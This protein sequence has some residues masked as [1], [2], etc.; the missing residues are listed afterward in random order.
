MLEAQSLSSLC[1]SGKELKESLKTKAKDYCKIDK[2]FCVDRNIQLVPLQL[3]QQPAVET[4]DNI[5][6]FH[7]R[8]DIPLTTIKPPVGDFSINEIFNKA[9]EHAKTFI[10]NKQYYSDKESQKEMIV[11]ANIVGVI[12]Q[13]GIG[14]TCLTKLILKQIIDKRLFKSEYAFYLQFREVDYNEETNLLSFLAKSLSLSW[15]NNSVRRNAVLQHLSSRNDITLIMDGFD[16]AVIDTT[17]ANFTIA[18]LYDNAKPETFIKNILKGTILEN[19]KKIITSRPRQL[20][21]IVPDL[22][23]KYLLNILGLDLE[24]QY[25]ICKNICDDNTD[26]VFNYIQQH[27]SIATYCYVPCNCIL[28]MHAVHRVNALQQTKQNKIS[29]PN[30]ISGILSVV[31]CL[32][33]SSPHARDKHPSF[34]LRKLAYLAWDGF[35]NR[36]FCFTET[37]LHKTELGKDEINLFFVT[38]MANNA[39]TIFGGSPLKISYFSHL[40][41][42]EFLS[43]LYLIYFLPL[44]VFKKL[45]IGKH[46]GVIK[47]KPPQLVVT[48]GNWELVTKFM[49][50]ICNL[51]TQNMLQ[52]SFSDIGTTVSDKADLL[53]DF[54]I[55]NFVKANKKSSENLSPDH[56]YFQNILS[57][58]TWVH[59][60]NDVKF[61]AS[62]ANKLK[63]N[64]VI[65][66]KVLPSDIA[67][68]NYT[69][70]ERKASTNLDC[71]HFETWFVGNSIDQFLIAMEQKSTANPQITVILYFRKSTS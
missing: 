13:A 65:K 12:G 7:H 11:C 20:L 41:I 68:F 9:N 57:V 29:M 34:P 56:I 69:L 17:S 61:A 26:K 67:S 31:L 60:L 32:F 6:Q 58:C 2:F 37:D 19:F 21:E 40:I 25:Q 71:T 15:I 33:V 16:E 14:K 18:N 48:E 49:F 38:K 35:R 22:R 66:G 62:I 43:A 23:P 70:F 10:A 42:Q 47:L 39:L 30:T 55:R 50:G 8:N 44:K 52:D 5:G 53:R 1:I 46:I 28:V 3:T 36:K 63:K 64:I 4:H 54:A 59:E 51:N 27:P 24:A 45:V